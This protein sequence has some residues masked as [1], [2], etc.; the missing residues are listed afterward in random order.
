MLWVFLNAHV[1]L[2]YQDTVA[3]KVSKTISKLQKIFLK[4]KMLKLENSHDCRCPCMQ[5]NTHRGLPW[6]ILGMQFVSLGSQYFVQIA[7][8]SRDI[9]SEEMWIIQGLQEKSYLLL[10]Y[11]Q[12]QL[13]TQNTKLKLYVPCRWIPRS[14]FGTIQNAKFYILRV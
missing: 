14:F 8:F 11:F 2:K 6:E 4:L 12:K 7:I 13:S 3:T 9:N 1:E 10:S 5:C